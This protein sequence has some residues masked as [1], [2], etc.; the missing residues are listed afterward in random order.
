MKNWRTVTFPNHTTIGI[1]CPLKRLALRCGRVTYTHA[2]HGGGLDRGSHA[3]S[4]AVPVA[5]DVGLPSV[6]GWRHTI[7]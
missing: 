1:A 6:S 5:Q 4:P 7:S 2:R 3:V